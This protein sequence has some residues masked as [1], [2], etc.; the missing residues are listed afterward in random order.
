MS[1]TL[2]KVIVKA[3]VEKDGKYLLAQRGSTEKHHAGVWSLPGGNVDAEVTNDIIEQ[4]VQRE[5]REEIGI[6][7]DKS[8]ELIY[9]NG[10]IK[11]SDGSHVINLTF[12][13]KYKSGEA[14]AL[15]DTES[16]AWYTLEE[17]KNLENK[18]DF[19]VQ[20]IS[21]LTKFIE[22]NENV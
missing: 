22:R 17:L 5:V 16:I 7:L 1:S 10:F 8:F 4:T 3:W 9:T 14:Q 12:L 15:E 11:E 19:L 21:Y 6:E 2:H 18:P 20:E 13:C